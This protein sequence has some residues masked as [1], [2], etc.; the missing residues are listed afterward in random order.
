MVMVTRSVAMAT[1][2][3]RTAATTMVLI[4]SWNLQALDGGRVVNGMRSDRFALVTT[5][6]GRVVMLERLG[7]R[8]SWSAMLHRPDSLET[9]MKPS[10][11][12]RREFAKVAGAALAS[13][14]APSIAANARSAQAAP[15]IATAGGRDPDLIVV[16]AKVYTMD[17][18]APRAEAFAVTSGPLHG[19]GLDG[20]HQGPGRQEHADV[21]RQGHDRSCPASSTATTTPAARCCSTRCSSAIPSKWSSSPSSASSAS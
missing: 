11:H 7:L 3:S 18:R 14:A 4:I 9:T 2:R 19:R 10:S 12:S 15:Q 16:N 6:W 13:L 17:T 20:R 8:S 5:L 21:R 1:C